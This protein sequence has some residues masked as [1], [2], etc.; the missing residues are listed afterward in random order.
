MYDQL[1][2]RMRKNTVEQ[3]VNQMNIQQVQYP[4][5]ASI[6]EPKKPNVPLVI[7]LALIGSQALAFIYVL[8]ARAK[9]SS[10][11]SVDEAERML[12]MPALAAVPFAKRKKGKKADQSPL[13]QLEDPASPQAEATR[14]LR[15]ALAHLPSGQ[16]RVVLFTSSVPGEGKSFCAVNYAIALAHQGLRT[17][18]I[19]GDLRRPTLARILGATSDSTGL[20]D[21]LGRKAALEEIWEP[22]KVA[23]LS[24]VSA[25]KNRARPAELLA[26]RKDINLLLESFKEYDCVVIDTAPVLVVSDS[27]LL[28][29]LADAVVLVIRARKTQQKE[30]TRS[31][32]L[33]N[34]V[35]AFP[36]GFV[37]NQVPLEQTYSN[38]SYA[39]HYASESKSRS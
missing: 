37:L 18:L 27:L 24:I 25:G 28:A 31:V 32:H 9:D 29:P 10:F 14:D 6:D 1:L 4:V 21:Y 22:T 36:V 26:Q 19:D 23:N 17:V 3:N 34:Q 8:F 30:I 39:G 16:P 35:G 7:G 13:F 2:E 12:Q 38:S 15:T 5:M 11:R 20:A 33:M